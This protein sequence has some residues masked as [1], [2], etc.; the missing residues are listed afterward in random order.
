MTFDEYVQRELRAEVKS[1]FH[2]GHVYEM[3]GGTIDH[4]RII[5]NLARRLSEKLEGKPCEPFE[6][7]LR[8]FSRLHD[9]GMYP[10][11]QVIC[12]P[13]EFHSPDVTRTT[14]INPTV[15]FEVLSPGTAAYDR[16]D[17]LRIYFTI[18]SLKQ[19]VLIESEKAVVEIFTR[20]AEGWLRTES[21][22]LD[23]S[24]TLGSIDVT[25]KLSELYLS[26]EFPP[27]PVAQ[28]ETKR[29]G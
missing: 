29:E 19:Y 11:G 9:R 4:S 1:E 2:A 28:L 5:R 20:T 10:D 24:A 25:L 6:A 18:P 23:A 21:A 27:P 17:K 26:V 13:V 15:V 12:G 7:N 22:G 16:G 8:V 3:S 14:I